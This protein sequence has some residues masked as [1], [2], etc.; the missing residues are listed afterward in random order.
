M[1]HTRLTV[2]T[3]QSLPFDSVGISK[4]KFRQKDKKENKID[5]V[6]LAA[7]LRLERS[8]SKNI[9]KKNLKQNNE[10]KILLCNEGGISP[11]HGDVKS[12]LGCSP[13]FS[14]LY[15]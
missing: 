15:S 14:D 3:G 10:S 7:N 9:F 5:K 13:F 4:I 12:V 1:Q 6:F 2:R 8:R 11:C